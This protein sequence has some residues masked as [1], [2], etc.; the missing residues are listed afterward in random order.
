MAT[1]RIVGATSLRPPGASI[2][3]YSPRIRPVSTVMRSNGDLIPGEESGDLMR[4]RVATRADDADV[5]AIRSAAM[6][7]R[8]SR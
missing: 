3:G 5:A 7:W 1:S 6:A 2:T 4:P 8:E